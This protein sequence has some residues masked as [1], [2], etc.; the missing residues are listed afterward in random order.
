ME[1]LVPKADEENNT[2]EDES[3]TDQHKRTPGSLWSPDIDPNIPKKFKHEDVCQSIKGRI[4]NRK[5]DEET[6]P[7]KLP[8]YSGTQDMNKEML[9]T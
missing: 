5:G 1:Y 6:M 9:E 2:E 3:G 7:L 8:I 4:L